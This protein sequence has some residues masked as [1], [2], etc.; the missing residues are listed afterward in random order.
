MGAA[1]IIEQFAA[2]CRCT[3]RPLDLQAASVPPSSPPDVLLASQASSVS[4]SGTMG[5][6][7][8]TM[9]VGVLRHSGRKEKA[10]RDA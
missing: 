4:R 6:A 5:A 7:G 8:P 3:G 2:V 10:T 1:V 9:T